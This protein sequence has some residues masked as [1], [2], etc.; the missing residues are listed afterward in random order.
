MA[1]SIYVV[2]IK[3]LG[4]ENK[5]NLTTWFSGLFLQLNMKCMQQRQLQKEMTILLFQDVN[6]HAAYKLCV[7]LI[8]Y[9]VFVYIMR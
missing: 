7:Y 4:D 1:S 3:H 8:I 2:E 5:A 6:I 9:K